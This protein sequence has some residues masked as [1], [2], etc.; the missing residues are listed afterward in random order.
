MKYQNISQRNGKTD[1]TGISR[2]L[3]IYMISPTIF[4]IILA[5]FGSRSTGNASEKVIEDL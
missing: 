1:I 3:I 4:H 5:C 2:S